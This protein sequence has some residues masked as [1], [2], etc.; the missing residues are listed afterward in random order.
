MKEGVR[1][2]PVWDFDA[3]PAYTSSSFVYRT[4]TFVAA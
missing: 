4:L 1:L 2:I 3:H